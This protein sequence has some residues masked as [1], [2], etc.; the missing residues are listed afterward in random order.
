MTLVPLN[1][2]AGVY[3]NGTDLQSQ[4]RWRDANLVRWIDGTLRPV[5]GWR[6][7]SNYAT[8]DKPRG[9]ISWAD[10]DA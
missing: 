6:K 4:G 3:R 5:G 9:M 8:R 10:N 7:R 1:I 2:P